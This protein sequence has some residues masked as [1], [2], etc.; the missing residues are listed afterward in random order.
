MDSEMMRLCR[1]HGLGYTRYVDDITVSG[2]ANLHPLR[3]AF[4]EIIRSAG[5][6]A[7]PKKIHIAPR[8]EPQ[9]VTGLIV[10]DRLHPTP[11]FVRELKE[12]IRRCW[13]GPQEI[14]SAAAEEGLWPKEFLRSLWGRVNHVKSVDKKLGQE[15]R[16]LCVRLPRLSCK[17]NGS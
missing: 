6:E 5:F 17:S 12:T 14:A 9:V 2:G 13:E 15:I 16:A 1:R 8:S 11:A 3:G 10:N 4:I 7:H